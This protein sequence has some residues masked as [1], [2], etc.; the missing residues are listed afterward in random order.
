M[1]LEQR[2][3]GFWWPAHVKQAGLKYYH[4]AMDMK[5]AVDRCKQRR[6]AIQA[7]GHIGMWPLWLAQRF[8]NVF[9]FEPNLENFTC[10]VRNITAAGSGINAK[11]C[12]H[13]GALNDRGGLIK[14]RVST[15]A[16][17]HSVE[18]ENGKDLEGD[19]ASYMIDDFNLGDVDFIMLD[20]EGHELPALRGA[21][22]TIMTSRPMIQV[23][24]RGHG[25]KK[26]RGDSFCDL[27]HFLHE[28]DYKQLCRVRNDVV[29]IP[30]ERV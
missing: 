25:V 17:G 30:K 8:D 12:A 16:G 3:K 20:I 5:P 18:S 27:E 6:V 19:T 13:H 24:D 14:M 2:E 1:K 28:L 29:F 26:G 22:R 7:G 11:V 15:N 21:I 4:H 9:T 23:E 10:L